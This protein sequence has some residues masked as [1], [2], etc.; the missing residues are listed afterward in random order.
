MA[1]SRSAH[2]GPEPLQDSLLQS[3]ADRG[4]VRHFPANAVLVTEEDTSDSLFIILRGRVKAYGAGADGREVVY[5]TQGVGEYFGE[6]TLDGG[7]RSASVMTLEASTCAVV[8]GTEVRDFLAHHPDFALHLV[9]KLIRL[10]RASTEQ[11]KSL[12]LDDV[13][14]RIARL[15]R[16]LAQPLAGENGVLL[17]PDKMTQQDIAERVGSSREMVSRIFKPLTEGG[18]VEL[19]AGRIALLKKLPARW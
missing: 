12:A 16:T 15:L 8:P 19:R 18:Y 7:P 4:G 17:L 6:M 2:P 9:K 1:S 5:G 3:I 14:G 13:Y 11:V 10:T